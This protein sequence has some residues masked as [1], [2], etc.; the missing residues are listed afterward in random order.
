VRLLAGES[1]QLQQTQSAEQAQ[2]LAV[3]DAP[4]ASWE[5]EAVAATKAAEEAAFEAAWI[6]SEEAREAL[7][8][9]N[10]QGSAEPALPPAPAPNVPADVV[11]PG[12]SASQPWDV[13]AEDEAEDHAILVGLG[14][15][16]PG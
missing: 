15:L 9:S 16:D 2:S 12:A 8:A 3:E 11:Q 13:E 1:A 10:A 14:L 4:F 7:A 6:A 5:K